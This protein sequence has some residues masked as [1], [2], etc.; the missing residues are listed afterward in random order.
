MLVLVEAKK[1]MDWAAVPA[2]VPRAKS[3]TSLIGE[4][5]MMMLAGGCW[6]PKRDIKV[7][8]SSGIRVGNHVGISS[9]RYVF[10]ML[11]Q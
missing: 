3:G 5:M 4:G 6:L 8:E 7:H 9:W 10:C 1:K 11:A 2:S